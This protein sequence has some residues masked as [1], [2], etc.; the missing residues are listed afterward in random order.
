MP[1]FAGRIAALE[2]AGYSNAAA[3]AKLAHDV[4]L[5]AAESCGLR[6]NLAIKGGVVMSSVTGDVRRA[7]MDMDIDFVRYGLSDENIDDWIGRLNC[8]DGIT[9]SRLGEMAELRQQNYRGKRVYLAIADSEGV[10]IST[11]IDIGVS[12]HEDMPQREMQFRISLDDSSA[13]LFANSVEQ[14]FAEKLKSLIR[15][16]TRSNRLKDIFDMFYLIDKVD[17]SNLRRFIS[18]MVFEDDKMRERSFEDICARVSRIFGAAAYKQRLSGRR[19]NWLQA[20]PSQVTSSILAFL[21]S[22]R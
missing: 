15:L 13:T 22:C 8:L 21:E 18:R 16:G 4:V 6:E 10:T 1:S 5:K 2:A 19:P 7:T 3:M 11:K 17:R 14:I 9:I 12:V 20:D